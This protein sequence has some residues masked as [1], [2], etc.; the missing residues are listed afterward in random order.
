VYLR[1]VTLAQERG[2]PV[3]IY[4]VHLDL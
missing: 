3:M 1:E 2:V 4:R